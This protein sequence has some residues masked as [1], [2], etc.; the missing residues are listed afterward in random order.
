M[1][2]AEKKHLIAILEAASEGIF[3][4]TERRPGNWICILVH[5]RW[6]GWLADLIFSALRWIVG[7]S[8]RWS[9]TRNPTHPYDFWLWRLRIDWLKFKHT[10]YPIIRAVLPTVIAEQIVSVQPM[11][12]CAGSM[13]E[14]KDLW[15]E[16]GNL[17]K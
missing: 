3:R 10:L 5:H 4:N 16:E 14:L 8:R 12:K 13:I 17:F 9:L 7:R 15:W 6:Y 1:T 11:D 2:D